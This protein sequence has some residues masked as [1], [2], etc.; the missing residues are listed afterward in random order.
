[1]FLGMD[2][3]RVWSG[4]LNFSVCSGL[5]FL[6]L[7]ASHSF[8]IGIFLGLVCAVVGVLIS[9]WGICRHYLRL[10]ALATNQALDD[11]QG[12][13]MAQLFRSRMHLTQV[14][15]GLLALFNEVLMFDLYGPSFFSLESIVTLLFAAM[16]FQRFMQNGAVY[17]P[18]WN[19]QRTLAWLRGSEHL[20]WAGHIRFASDWPDLYSYLVLAGRRY[21]VIPTPRLDLLLQSAALNYQASQCDEYEGEVI[22][23][24]DRVN[25]RAM[26]ELF[27]VAAYC[28]DELQD[29][30]LGA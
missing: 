12:K 5:G 6:Y 20:S 26:A 24:E 25:Y 8:G 17:P 30:V 27:E 10:A 1:M 3:L 21:Q 13:A 9:Y 22:G 7:D 14:L 4:F 29:G 16:A 11:E 19:W 23:P 15:G 2:F 28:K 18:I